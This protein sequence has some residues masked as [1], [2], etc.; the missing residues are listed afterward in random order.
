MK[1][2][3]CLALLLAACVTAVTALRSVSCQYASKNIN[4]TLLDTYAYAFR[5]FQEGASRTAKWALIFESL[6]PLTYLDTSGSDLLEY[7]TV[8]DQIQ[9]QVASVDVSVAQLKNIWI[10]T[11]TQLSQTVASDAVIYATTGDTNGAFSAYMRAWG[12]S[13]TAER[14]TDHLSPQALSLYNQS[15]YYHTAAITVQRF[16]CSLV[17]VPYTPDG[18][19]VYALHAYWCPAHQDRAARATVVVS[20]GYDGT[21]E[22][23][24]HE[25]GL[26]LNARGYSVLVFD[27]PG[28]GYTVRYQGPPFRH[29][30]EF[31]V[32][33]VLNYLSLSYGVD[34]GQVVL[35]GQSFGGFLAPKAFAQ[36]PTVAACVANGG[37]YD[38]LQTLSCPLGSAL[39]GLMNSD[40]DTFNAVVT[41]N[42]APRNLGT[43]GVFDCLSSHYVR[44][45]LT[46]CSICAAPQA[47][48]AFCP[49]AT[50]GSM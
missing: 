27:G 15:L 20:N 39:I 24:L 43:Y 46:T 37:I 7:L 11:L 17:G 18:V 38:F 40:P 4:A 30:W 9:S 14:L 2:V 45:T 3:V 36:L 33:Q 19:S 16:P 35:W 25:V 22:M 6:F 29:D 12:Y 26:K 13:M 31:V 47:W 21:A 32:S 23:L 50:W 8:L 5:D 48:T 1:P 34:P 41:N 44:C 10:S 49:T 42:V 28:Q